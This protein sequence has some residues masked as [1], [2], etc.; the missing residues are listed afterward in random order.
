[1]E[2]ITMILEEFESETSTIA[3]YARDGKVIYGYNDNL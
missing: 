3:D 2:M 1:M